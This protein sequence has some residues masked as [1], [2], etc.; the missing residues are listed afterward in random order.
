MKGWPQYVVFY[1]F[2]CNTNMT[3]GY[4][5]FNYTRDTI[6]IKKKKILVCL[7]NEAEREKDLDVEQLYTN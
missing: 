2:I 3:S 1:I 7:L 6:L 5:H 4:V